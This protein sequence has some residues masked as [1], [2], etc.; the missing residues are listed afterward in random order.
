MKLAD[1]MLDKK[2]NQTFYKTEDVERDFKRIPTGIFPLDLSIGGGVPVGVSSCL[3]GQPSSGKSLVASRVMAVS[4]RICWNCFDY[5]DYCECG[6]P[7]RKTPVIV[8]NEKFDTRWGQLLGLDLSDLFISEADIGEQFV[9]AAY[10]VLN[11]DDV[12]LVVLDSLSG[13]IPEAEITESA[14][15]N[16]MG[17][18][19]RLQSTLMR[20]IQSALI[21]QKRKKNNAMVLAISQVRANIGERWGPDEVMAG[22]WVAKHAFHLTCKL[23]QLKTKPEFID[24]ETEMPIFGRFKSSLTTSGIKKKLFIMAGTSEFFVCLKDTGDNYVGEVLDYKTVFKYADQVGLI[25]R[26]RWSSVYD[27][28]KFPSKKEMMQYWK[29]NENYYLHLKK[30]IVDYYCDAEKG[31]IE[32]PEK[33]EVETEDE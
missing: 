23:S 4:Q 17:L 20:K 28:M 21:T 14:M 24:K 15:K 2:K 16:H 31:L 19:A 22:G 27:D 33:Q 9:D 29:E 12:G 26:D 6:N 8:E 25:D 10:D 7:L 18:Q 3:F 30:K 32:M 11:A 5:L 1:L 13:V